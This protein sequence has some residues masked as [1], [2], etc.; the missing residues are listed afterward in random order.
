MEEISVCTAYEGSPGRFVPGG[1]ALGA[2]RPV[3]ETLQGWMTDIRGERRWEA[4]PARA[5]EYVEFLEIRTGAPV[6]M[7]STGPERSD[8]IRRDK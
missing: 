3:Y 1:R 6:T 4:L 2:C 7:I 8:L 5:R